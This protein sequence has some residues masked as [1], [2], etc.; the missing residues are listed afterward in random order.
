MSQTKSNAQAK[1]TPLITPS[2]SPP[3][4]RPNRRVSDTAS[5]SKR[6]RY[7]RTPSRSFTPL[8]RP[9][10]DPEELNEARCASSARVLEVW[11]QLAERYA[12]GLDEDDIIDLRHDTVIKDRGF[13]RS[14]SIQYDIGC[15]ADADD[16][17]DEDV[18]DDIDELDAFS[19]EANISDE[20]EM[21]RQKRDVPPVQAMDPDDARDL[22]EFLEE[23]ERRRQA[24]GDK[25]ADDDDD[26][27]D[28]RQ[29]GN[30]DG[31]SEDDLSATSQEDNAEHDSQEDTPEG[32]NLY[33]HTS[34]PNRDIS[35]SN[36]S[37]HGDSSDSSEDEL[38]VEA[39]EQDEGSALFHVARHS[40]DASEQVVSQSPWPPPSTSSTT[41][42][43]ASR[44]NSESKLIRKSKRRTSPTPDFSF[45]AQ[46]QTPPRSQSSTIDSIPDTYSFPDP[47]T[48]TPTRTLPTPTGDVA[49]V[50]HKLRGSPT[51]LPKSK[52]SA[53]ISKRPSGSP[54]QPSDKPKSKGKISSLNL[55][56][57]V[58]IV[59]K[60]D[61]T[62][63]TK[64]PR[65][66]KVNVIEIPV[67]PEPEDG[68]L[69]FDSPV[70]VISEFDLPSPQRSQSEES[71]DPISLSPEI[72]VED[73]SEKC[74]VSK[75]R[76]G[77]KRKRV[78][79]D[80]E[81]F[82]EGDDC[83]KGDS[84]PLTSGVNRGRSQKSP[85]MC[86]SASGI[87]DSGSGS[88]KFRSGD[89]FGERTEMPRPPDLGSRP[90]NSYR[91]SE[92][93]QI[94]P[95]L[96]QDLKLKPCSSPQVPC[97]SPHKPHPSLPISVTAH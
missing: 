80:A 95:I 20:L 31:F 29:F 77:K 65:N 25:D 8:S 49:K 39:W 87:S 21:E 26:V 9:P 71:D 66:A 3:L 58:L 6:P 40:E 28:F 82:D 90:R 62:H 94:R 56:P 38:A 13:L 35:C 93:H 47:F 33:N 84:S 37:V 24:C 59:K 51:P 55:P 42:Q 61:K 70:K 72:N 5:P 27:L 10:R 30:E 86:S 17:V 46:L 50:L 48:S 97:G 73:R 67:S 63:A 83:G 92:T 81:E 45:P 74:L 23:E 64:Q 85:F 52:R 2:A 18:D 15:F 14:T 4:S 41:S 91:R 19:P 7:T 44:V 54:K 32:W 60:K 76:K 1:K 79:S 16:S 22:K 53:P 36:S 12:R 88:S 78:A 11:S 68:G 75:F 69:E 89:L 43:T 96:S 57:H 34:A